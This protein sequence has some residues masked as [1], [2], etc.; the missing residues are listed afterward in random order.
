MRIGW[1]VFLRAVACVVLLAGAALPARAAETEHV[2]GRLV[3]GYRGDP[4]SA[5]LTR[6]L[7]L[8]RAALRRH[9]PTLGMHTIDVPEEA[10]GV[11]LESLRA[12][13]LFDY[14]ERD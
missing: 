7:A 6:T 5:A 12:T 14:V 2:P 3:A 10:S 9:N 8:H 11:I 4:N 1:R 13:G